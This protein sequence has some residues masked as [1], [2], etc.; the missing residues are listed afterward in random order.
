[1]RKKGGKKSTIK[2]ASK[3]KKIIKLRLNNGA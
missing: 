1:M 3:D 2:K